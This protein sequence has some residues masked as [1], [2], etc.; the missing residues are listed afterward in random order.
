MTEPTLKR[1]PCPFCG[2]IPVLVRDPYVVGC[3]ACSIRTET[4]KTKEEALGKWNTRPLEDKEFW[5]G[6]DACLEMVKKYLEDCEVIDLTQWAAILDG[7]DYSAELYRKD[8]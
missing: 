4:F 1:L 2:K 5:S 8:G 6:F 7:L 3:V